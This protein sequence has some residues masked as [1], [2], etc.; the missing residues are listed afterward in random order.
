[1]ALTAEQIAKAQEEARE[2]LEYSVFKIGLTLGLLPED[3]SGSMIVPVEEGH[4]EYASYQSLIRQA[5]IL[6]QMG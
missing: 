6:E 3:I 2:F 5:L 4:P 1:M